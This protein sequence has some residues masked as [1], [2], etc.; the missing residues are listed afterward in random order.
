VINVEAGPATIRP[1]KIA[2]AADGA[3]NG[4]AG[5][6]RTRV[7][8][9]HHWLYRVDTARGT[10]VVIRQNTGE[11]AP[12]EGARVHLTWRAEE[13][14]IGPNK[15]LATPSL[16]IPAVRAGREPGPMT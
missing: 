13:L 2:F 10:L 7:F 1:E 5:T 6:V 9:G 12:V 8:Q 4:L 14:M 15:R 11:A 3:A 16:V